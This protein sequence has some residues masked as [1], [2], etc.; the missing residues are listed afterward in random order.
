MLASLHVNGEVVGLWRCTRSSAELQHLAAKA[1]TLF[2]KSAM[3]LKCGAINLLRFALCESGLI[4]ALVD[5]QN[6]KTTFS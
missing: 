3:G 6:S 2:K 5:S 4:A 1:Y